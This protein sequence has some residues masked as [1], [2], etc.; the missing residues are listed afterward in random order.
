MLRAPRAAATRATRAPRRRP[1]AAGSARAPSLLRQAREQRVHA[2]GRILQ[3]RDH[4]GAERGIVGVALGVARDQRQLADEVLDVV[5]DEGEAAVELV[6]PLRLGQRGVRAILGQIARGLRARRR[7]SRSKS[8][9]SSARS[10][11]GRA[12][13]IAPASAPPWISGTIAQASARRE[14]PAG[15]RCGL[16]RVGAA[17]AHRVQL[18]DPAGAARDG[19]TSARPRAVGRAVPVPCRA[20]ARAARRRGDQQQPGR[21]IG[22]VGDRLDDARRQRRGVAGRAERLGEALP[23]GAVVVAVAE[24]V[25]GDLHLGPGAQPRRR[26]AASAA[27]RSRRTRSRSATS[28]AWSPPNVAA[29]RWSASAVSRA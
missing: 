8:S 29:Q 16:R 6:E 18:D 3:R 14:Q 27:P 11:G 26:A 17:R 9:Q 21:R 10:T 12:S 5:E 2:V 7:A 28:R 20:G 15:H 22:Q 23:L 19:A 25:L 1:A 13:T 4:V 24:Q